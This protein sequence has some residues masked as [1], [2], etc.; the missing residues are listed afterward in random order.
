MRSA[1]VFGLYTSEPFEELEGLEEL[2]GVGYIGGSVFSGG[3]GTTGSR[4]TGK[5]M[6]C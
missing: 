5:G 2:D 1:S 6:L 3:E 4:I